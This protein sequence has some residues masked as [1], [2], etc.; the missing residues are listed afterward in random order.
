MRSVDLDE[1]VRTLEEMGDILEITDANPF[2]IMAYR[3]GAQSLAEWEGDLERACRE[4]K[5]TE[6]EGIGKGLSAMIGD[7]VLHGR[8]EACERLR[9][10]VPGTLRDLLQVPRL[11]P[12]RIRK[13]HRELGVSSIEGLEAAAR[14][15]RIRTLAGFGPKSEEQILSGIDRARRYG[16][17]S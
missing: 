10:T 4:G 9:G 15:G 16:R 17:I 8:S 2:Q 11:G 1:V 3:N 12:K 13:L 14:E 7:L 5:L 6:I